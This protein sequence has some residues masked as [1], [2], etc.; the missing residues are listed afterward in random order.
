[1]RRSL[2]ALVATVVAAT[3]LGAVTTTS[4]SASAEDS[5]SQALG[6]PDGVTA[7]MTGPD[8]SYAVRTTPLGDFPR[9]SAPGATPAHG[10]D[11]AYV[12]LSTGLADDVFRDLGP[13]RQ[14]STDLPGVDTST[15]TLAVQPSAQQ[16]CLLLD[17]A[18]G[19]EE[20]V[21]TYDP[22]V[23]SDTISIRRNGEPTE[24][25]MH[26]GSQLITQDGNPVK[27]VPYQV[28]TIGYWH[29]PGDEDDRAVGSSSESWLPADATNLDHL[30]VPETMQVP[31][32]AGSTEHRVTV[33]VSDVGND[34]LD[35]VALVDRVRVLP[36]CTGDPAQAT[37]LFA[38]GMTIRGDRGV[39]NSLTADLSSATTAIERYDALDNGWWAG[40]GRGV[41]L[42]FRWYETTSTR[43]LS[44][45]LSEWTPIRDADR[46][47][48][49]P[50]AAQRNKVIMVLVTGLKDGWR[51][52][53]FPS[54]EGGWDPTLPIGNGQFVDTHQPQILD[55]ESSA[56]P[57][58]VVT[59]QRLTAETIDFAPLQ[60]HFSYQWQ[61]DGANI[62]GA[63]NKDF[64]VT[65][66]QAG[67]RITV[68]VLAARL[69]FDSRPSISEPTQPVELLTMSSTPRP[70]LTGTPTV[71][72]AVG[73]TLA[74]WT[75]E[76]AR[77]SQRWYLDGEVQSTTSTTF[78][79]KPEHAGSTL[80]VV[81]T[82]S[83]AGYQP[84]T[85]RSVATTISASGITA[86]APRISGTARVGQRLS[87]TVSGWSPSGL[88]YTFTWKAGTKV[89]KSGT[90]NASRSL[91]VP[92]SAR[93]QRIVLSVEA[94]R[95]GYTTTSRDSAATAVVTPGVLTSATPRITGTAKVGSTLRAT[96]GSWGPSPVTLTY[97][98]YADGKL[99]SGGTK[100]SITLGTGHR[101]KRIV[102]KVTG[103]KQ[104]YTS[105]TKA[106]AATAKV[107]R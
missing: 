19:T 73:Y 51:M 30:T 101:G 24:Y 98:W 97:R 86:T 52:E 6:L 48:F 95:A 18:M 29:A 4:S 93:G 71:G 76:G 25:A 3:C 13:A 5:L 8:G 96:T 85:V 66:A 53:T 46:Q 65:E 78:T 36:T 21:H 17:L 84:V 40:S 72:K 47:T 55:K 20:R 68:R 15:L 60:D 61:A 103:A 22:R 43:R 74:P 81:A 2:H 90:D 104:G 38:P 7:A 32:R 67:K 75:P 11:A 27:P 58:R 94:T 33:S 100:S 102:L 64:V 10:Q 34:L 31:L 87:G 77:F 12:L 39:G 82:G 105:V 1:M 26:A 79:P 54:P 16:R 69:N 91:V 41:D 80:E 59:G 106:S 45:K 50:T 56:P 42:R 35:S 88:S 44:T 9:R 63:Q 70:V 62:L 83:K 23:L 14:P 28:N 37:G 99:M 92:A 49:V 89:L 57:S 107:I